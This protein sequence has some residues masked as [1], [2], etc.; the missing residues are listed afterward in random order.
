MA[1]GRHLRGL[2]VH[3]NSGRSDD[4]ALPYTGVLNLD[5]VINGLLDIGYRGVFT[6]EAERALFSD[7]TSPRQRF[8]RDTRL[9]M[10]TLEMVQAAERLLYTIGKCALE[11]YDVFEG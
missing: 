3:D 8:E 1:L 7:K 10:P 4:H 2:H 6:F 5:A 11:A 9:A